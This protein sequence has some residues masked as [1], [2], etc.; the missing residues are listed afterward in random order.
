MWVDQQTLGL[1]DSVARNYPIGSV[2]LWQTTERLTSERAIAG[3]DAKPQRHG[4]PLNYEIP[5]LTP[6]S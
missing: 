5:T 6:S 4:Y 3:L 1:L 2:L